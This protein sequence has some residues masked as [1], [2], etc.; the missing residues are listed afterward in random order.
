MKTGDTLN[1]GETT[2]HWPDTMFSYLSG[3]NILFSNDGFGQHFAT[4]SLYDDTVDPSALRYEAEKY[5][6]NILKRPV[7]RTLCRPPL[8]NRKFSPA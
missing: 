1:L 2:L 5:Y 8:A 3:E 4:E 7:A 6:A